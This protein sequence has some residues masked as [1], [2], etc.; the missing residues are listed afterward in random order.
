MLIAFI[1]GSCY[2]T[3][4]S[5]A[6]AMLILPSAILAA[7]AVLF[8]VVRPSKADTAMGRTVVVGVAI[9]CFGLVGA[10]FQSD[11]QSAVFAAIFLGTWLSIAACAG[12][13]EIAD[14]T[15]SFALSGAIVMLGFV[16]ID[17]AN[18]STS[19]SVTGVGKDILSRY[20]GPFGAHPNLMGHIAGSY[21]VAM[22]WQARDERFVVKIMLWAGMVASALICVAASSRGGLFAAIG[23]CML[24]YAYEKSKSLKGTLGLAVMATA[25]LVATILFFPN[26]LER[27]DIL[28]D[29]SNSQRGL[30]SGFSGRTQMW[31]VVLD[32]FGTANEPLVWGAGFRSTWLTQLTDAIDNGYLMIAAEIGVIGL[33]LWLYQVLRS[34]RGAYMASRATGSTVNLMILSI[35]IFFLAESI[36]ARYFLA[37]G[38][39]ASVFFMI[40]IILIPSQFKFRRVVSV[41][42]TP[43][44]HRAPRSSAT[45]PHKFGHGKSRSTG[46][47]DTQLASSSPGCESL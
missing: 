16:A 42:G 4:N 28:L 10:L 36:V 40:L 33:A 11:A 14:V 12:A 15:K 23:S 35:I 5:I 19:L 27:T 20:M 39:G 18:I 9:A 38:N 6:E 25:A 30:N 31:Q 8:A 29:L 47:D 45:I 34:L 26:I 37:I 46:L 17:H 1:G 32:Q 43:S 22:F 24:V 41:R 44:E 7:L 13:L 3:K 21:L 2:G